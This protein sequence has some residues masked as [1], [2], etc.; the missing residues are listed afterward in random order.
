MKRLVK[1]LREL[2]AA[3]IPEGLEERLINAI[4]DRERAREWRWIVGGAV[5]AGL[6]LSV[7]VVKSH[8]PAGGKAV[9]RAAVLPEFVVERRTQ[10]QETKP[11]FVLPLLPES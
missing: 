5:A 10:R 1:R 8:P 7:V 3:R 11:C 9:I 2:P 4:P 6:L